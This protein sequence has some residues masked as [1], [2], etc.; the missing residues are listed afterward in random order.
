IVGT[1]GID[2][3]RALPVTASARNLPSFKKGTAGERVLKMIGV[4]PAIA[5]ASAGPPPLCGTCT[6]SSPNDIRNCSPAR[7]GWVPVPPDAKLYL[8]GLALI[9]ATSSSTLLGGSEGCTERTAGDLTAIV[10]GAKSLTGSNGS[11][12]NMDEFVACE[13]KASR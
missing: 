3:E 13:L 5:D 11:L 7:W 1:S 10:I 2:R 6:R 12:S 9:N 4:C 8:P